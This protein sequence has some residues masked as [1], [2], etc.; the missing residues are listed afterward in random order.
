[1]YER[2]PRNHSQAIRSSPSFASSSTFAEAT[3]TT[4]QCRRD[5]VLV[6][7]FVY[8][9]PI[10]EAAGQADLHGSPLAFAAYH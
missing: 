5:A 4:N 1:M 6:M 7:F 2:K 3:L 8:E 9:G 10:G